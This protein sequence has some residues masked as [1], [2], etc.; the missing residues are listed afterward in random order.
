MEEIVI[1][2]H[3]GQEVGCMDAVGQN[4][5][6]LEKEEELEGPTNL[7]DSCD[8]WSQVDGVSDEKEAIGN[9]Q[10]DDV[11]DEKEAMGEGSLARELGSRDGPEGQSPTSQDPSGVLQNENRGP[12]GQGDELLEMDAL[13]KEAGGVDVGPKALPE[14]GAQEMEPTLATGEAPIAESVEQ[15]QG[16]QMKTPEWQ[17]SRA[18]EG[19]QGHQRPGSQL[20]KL[21][22][23]LPH[24]FPPRQEVKDLSS[25]G[26]AFLDPVLPPSATQMLAMSQDKI[27]SL[28][29][30]K[31]SLLDQIPASFQENE[32]PLLNPEL[33][34]L[35]NRSP[36]P[37]LNQN[38]FLPESK[39]SILDQTLSSL[40]ECLS[41]QNLPSLQDPVSSS[42]ETKPSPLQGKIPP[43]SDVKHSV[44][45]QV[46]SSL[47]EANETFSF[48][49]QT[50]TRTQITS[51]LDRPVS[52]LPEMEPF[53]LE[54]ISSSGHEMEKTI[55][56]QGQGLFRHEV[57][58]SL[59][60]SF[61]SLTNHLSSLPDQTVPLQEA[62]ISALEETSV[63]L[64]E[65]M[66]M[67]PEAKVLPLPEGDVFLPSQVPLSVGDPC[68]SPIVLLDCALPALQDTESTSPVSKNPASSLQEVDGALPGEIQAPLPSHTSPNLPE[69]EGSSPDQVPPTSEDQ[70]TTSQLG[71]A[72]SF[73]EAATSLPEGQNSSDPPEEKFNV[74]EPTPPPNKAQTPVLS[75]ASICPHALPLSSRE[76][77]QPLLDTTEALE[78]LD[79]KGSGASVASAGAGEVTD[80]LESLRAEQQPLLQE[81]KVPGAPLDISVGEPQ[82]KAGIL[83]PPGATSQQA[84]N[85]ISHPSANTAYSPQLQAAPPRQGQD[86]EPERGKHKSCQCCTLM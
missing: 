25:Q 74:A 38:S 42:L 56:P 31:E 4:Q 80:V 8:H 61:P 82:P 68:E 83:K 86:Q 69:D 60:E 47:H 79:A 35:S 21:A 65:P 71:Q 7:G 26:E 14:Q 57:D 66:P 72:P 19:G 63:P 12:K 2:D 22:P 41:E 85:N 75:D 81:D 73:Q 62:K 39:G 29:G 45:D 51:L 16:S 52:P 76:S 54:H 36:L 78:T 58:G 55:T 6:S 30:T 20:E 64:Q 24:Q 10:V 43:L 28:Q 53:V 37:P 49:S 1:R 44:M 18:R 5:S 13:A 23:S 3:L 40:P 32:G 9:G 67:A 50:C 48:W 84:P 27:P 46:P 34:F 33:P 70:T 77:L 17:K 15:S 11:S 59:P